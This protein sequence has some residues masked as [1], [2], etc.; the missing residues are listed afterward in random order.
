MSAAD[1]PTTITIRQSTR[2][3]LESVKPAGQTYD[4]L[5]VDLVDEHY[6]P[7][8]IAELKQRF[9]ARTK[10]R[11]AAEVYREWGV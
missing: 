8:L 10:A 1:G 4:D 9:S 2:R 7:E 11:P 5:L 3:L 6:S